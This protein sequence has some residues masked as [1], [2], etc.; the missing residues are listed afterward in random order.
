MMKVIF[1]DKR[2]ETMTSVGGV[3]QIQ[4]KCIG[5]TN[6]RPAKVW[7]LLMENREELAFKKSEFEIERVEI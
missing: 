4:S 5:H 6:G 2:R 1:Y 3:L 7:L